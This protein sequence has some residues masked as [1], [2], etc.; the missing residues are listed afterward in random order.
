MQSVRY[1]DQCNQLL[2]DSAIKM[3]DAVTSFYQQLSQR[4]PKA[5]LLTDPA[6]L[7]AFGTD[8][9]FYRLIPQ[10]VVLAES[11]EDIQQILALSARYNVPL[12]FRAA[13]TS[14]SGQ[15]V[16]DS[17]LVI[18]AN[19]WTGHRVLNNG[20]KIT[21]QVGVVASQA[22]AILAPLGRKI[23]PDPASINTCRIGGI[24]ANNSS[25]MCCGV[26]QNTYHTLDSIRLLLADGT[27]L[28]TA[29][30]DNVT[31]FRQSHKKL[32][33]AL[34]DL[35]EQ[36][37]SNSQLTQRI[38]HKFRLKNTTG[39]SINA[40]VD[41]SDPVDML[42]HLMIGSE[43]T[44]SFIS[45]VTYNTVPEYA[46]KASALVVFTDVATCC[47]AVTAL[48]QA[49]VA[50][51]ELMDR[52][53]MVSVVGKPGLPSFINENLAENACALLIETRAE[54]HAH[55]QQQVNEIRRVIQEFTVLD[56]VD[57]TEVQSEYAALWAIRKG[58][59]PAVGA[60]RQIGTTV[61]I[62]DVAFPVAQLTEGV[63]RLQ[64]LF[65]EFNYEEALIFGHAL[66]GNLHF[67]FTQSFD[68][69]QEIER[70]R[71]FMAAVSQLVAVEF[72]GSLKAEHGT[73]RN[74]APFVELEW[75][76]DA[77]Q[78]M[79]SVKQLFDQNNLL[80]PGVILN[81]DPNAHI[82]N[83]KPMPAADEL[84][85]KCIEC[86]FCEPAC[87]SR[88]LT[89]TPRKRIVL[90]REICRLRRVVEDNLATK[91]DKVRLKELEK[92]YTWQGIDT[93]AA[94]G[95]CSLR[96]PVGIN[97]GALTLKLREQNNR[98][99]QKTAQWLGDHF[100]GVTATVRGGLKAADVV[101]GV[102]GTD[103]M[104][105][106]SQVL[107]SV[108][109]DRLPLWSRGMPGSAKQQVLKVKDVTD[110]RPAVVYFPSCASRNM[111]PARMDFT[112][113]PL[114]EVVIRLLHKSGYRVIFPD[115]LNS[116]CCGQPFQSKGQ[117]D[118]ANSKGSELHQALIRA[119]ENGRW[120]VL[121]DT[122]SCTNQSGSHDDSLKA[123][124]LV[125]F[126]S[127]H[128]LDK[129]TLQKTNEPVMVHIPCSLQKRGGDDAIKRIVS[130][131]TTDMV[132]PD[133]ITCCGFAGD[134]GFNTPQLN[135]SALAPLK[136]QVPD[137]CREGVST[138]RTCEIGLSHHSGVPYHSVAYLLDRCVVAST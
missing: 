115:G 21:L 89:L 132:I 56:Q 42:A 92:E 20:E 19:G 31:A 27:L 35:S 98:K 41:F 68:T 121:F 86:G 1:N 7:L 135:A 10:L 37:K 40:L 71:L 111:A 76:R 104:T 84:V 96:C 100:G 95:L 36:V 99:Y 93:C 118:I 116:L 5:R 60:V 61:I 59:F 53:A 94:C 133:E 52:R 57:F 109:K 23:G 67:V 51:V 112:Q 77:Y 44:L 34:A 8:A 102:I 106:V 129:L 45:S 16:T 30:A 78:L 13:G 66:E 110:E 79:Q 38:R 108:S 9:S 18:A 12:T 50:A 119:S 22:N 103:A 90:W 70:Y 46:H 105:G 24:A 114:A 127:E 80:N 123:Y 113:E 138:N 126:I 117:A 17:V 29:N 137:G 85:D 65:D 120:P 14:L 74:M 131:C 47:R 55:L 82:T 136:A 134:K 39:Y 2:Y 72:G 54:N 43:G 28:D 48:S 125:E 130:A 32:L 49:P 83:L 33:D 11:E 91:D 101:H 73:G 88:S 128:L 3:N 69:P 26:A 107:R 4:I 63:I 75:G 87:P 15:A 64:A 81:D 62:E 6:R 58:L 122:S 124:D 97:T 25:G